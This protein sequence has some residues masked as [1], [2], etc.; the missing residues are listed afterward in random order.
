[1]NI[2]KKIKKELLEAAENTKGAEAF[3][4]L[5]DYEDDRLLSNIVGGQRERTV[6]ADKGYGTCTALFSG[7]A[8]DGAAHESG[9]AYPER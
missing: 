2:E 6:D 7:R 1:M 3:V 4:L 5:I 9:R 8:G